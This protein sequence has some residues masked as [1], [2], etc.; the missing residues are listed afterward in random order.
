[1]YGFPADVMVAV[2]VGYVAYVL[3]DEVL[4]LA[5]RALG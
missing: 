4:I 2:H 3:I 5:D 1:M